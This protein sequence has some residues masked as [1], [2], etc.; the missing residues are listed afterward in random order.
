MPIAESELILN[1]DGSIYHLNLKP[2][3]LAKNIITVGDP[4]RVSKVSAFLDEVTLKKQ[5]REFCTHTGRIGQ[6]EVSIISTGIGTDNIDI[7]MNEIDALFNVDF[8]TREVKEDLTSLNFIRI[9]TSGALQTDIKV[10]SIIVSEYAFGFDTLMRFYK[11]RPADEIAQRLH[12]DLNELLRNKNVYLLNYITTA[13]KTLF[14]RFIGL[15]KPG[16]TITNPGF[17]APQNRSVRAELKFPYYKKLI[18]D[19]ESKKR[20]CTNMEMETAG[21]YGLAELFGHQAISLNAI[22]ANRANGK[23]S[24][25]PNDTV[26]HLIEKSLEIIEQLDHVESTT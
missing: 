23:F 10:D 12:R 22:L 26:N 8:E 17:Y 18:Q 11:Y 3:E 13:S 2:G 14:E 9:G 6:Q 19:F 4:D 7:V 16:V 1:E 20:K 25:N 15:G 21:I 24:E 5:K